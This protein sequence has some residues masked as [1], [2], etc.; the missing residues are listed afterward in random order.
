M[1]CPLNHFCPAAATAAIACQANS[2][3]AATGATASS[4]CL[5]DPG[6]VSSCSQCAQC[7]ANSFCA[8]GAQTTACPTGLY[9]QPGAYSAS[10]PRWRRSSA[11]RA[12]APR[13]CCRSRTQRPCSAG[14]NA[15]PARWTASVSAGRRPSA[16]AAACACPASP[17]R[18]RATASAWLACKRRA[19]PTRTRSSAPPPAP[20]MTATAV[21]NASSALPTRTVPKGSSPTAR[22]GPSPLQ[23]RRPRP[24]ARACLDTTCRRARASNVLQAPS[25]LEDRNR[26]ALLAIIV[27][28]EPYRQRHAH[29]SKVMVSFF[30][31]F[32]YLRN[33]CILLQALFVHRI[34]PA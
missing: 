3:T 19:R 10:A 18:A 28:Q 32:F 5:C 34:L 6:F 25:A 29:R 23:D 27:Q 12:C 30:L 2:N 26:H 16:P 24:P 1:I 20:A 15:T 21:S 22:R 4:Q 17:A 31:I 14:G 7:A 8:G 33:I 13:A 9:S 11:P